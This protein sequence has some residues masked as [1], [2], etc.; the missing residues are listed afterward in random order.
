MVIREQASLI[1]IAEFVWENQRKMAESQIKSKGQKIAAVCLDH[2]KILSD[3]VYLYVYVHLLLN[4]FPFSVMVFD[5]LY[6]FRL[7]LWD[8]DGRSYSYYI[9]VSTDQAHWHLVADKTREACRYVH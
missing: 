7:L 5:F 1:N 9:E 2:P 4:H 8:C 3:S 6:V